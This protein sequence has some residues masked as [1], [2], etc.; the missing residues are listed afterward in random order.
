MCSARGS[1]VRK[2]YEGGVK[3]LATRQTLE[4][5]QIILAAAKRAEGAPMP[6]ASSNWLKRIETS[7]PKDVD[8]RSAHWTQ[9]GS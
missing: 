8:R 2:K 7:L 6:A 3:D 9:V 4:G 1:T 5:A